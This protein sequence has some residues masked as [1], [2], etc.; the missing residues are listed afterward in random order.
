M[1][2]LEEQG[3]D[4]TQIESS[5]K[6]EQKAKKE[7]DE[8]E[9]MASLS[10]SHTA[11]LSS[12]FSRLD[13][14][15]GENHWLSVGT[16]KE[17]LLR[18]Q[19]RAVLPGR[20]RVDTGFSL[21]HMKTKEGETCKRISRQIDILGWDADQY[22]PL[23]VDGEFVVVPAHSM[24]CAIEVKGN[25][26]REELKDGLHNLDYAFRSM[27]NYLSPPGLF[28]AL[29]AYELDEASGKRVSFPA[30]I[31]NQLY[32]L[33]LGNVEVRLGWR[34]L[35]NTARKQRLPWIDMVVVRGVGFVQLEFRRL[36]GQVLPVYVAYKLKDGAEDDTFGFMQRQLCWTLNVRQF[37]TATEKAAVNVPGEI[38]AHWFERCPGQSAMVLPDPKIKVESVWG[39]SDSGRVEA[40]QQ[41]LFRAR[42]P[43][44]RKK[45]RRKTK[46]RR[47]ARVS[48][49]KRGS[50]K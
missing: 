3:A 31:F 44:V 25:L 12:K 1:S 8:I 17:S 41:E 2:D 5:S 42:K 7:L 45:K 14:L 39:D 27:S 11:E 6:P 33:Y 13:H 20:F 48:G 40:I 46:A 38:S 34:P 50:P 43:T 4:E 10:A 37:S 24:R 9:V 21:S 26:N 28:T 47:I 19:L 18:Q 29:Y 35:L 32:W 23:F 15:I 49:K 22:S 16:Y 36:N 30:T